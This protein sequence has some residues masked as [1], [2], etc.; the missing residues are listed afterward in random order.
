MLVGGM[1]VLACA[2]FAEDIAPMLPDG[3]QPHARALAV[4]F[5]DTLTGALGGAAQASPD[6]SAIPRAD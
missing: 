5:D 6:D 2:I 4:A 3:M 1:L